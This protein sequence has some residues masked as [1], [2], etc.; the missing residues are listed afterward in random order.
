MPLE[1]WGI[2]GERDVS[3]LNNASTVFL[4]EHLPNIADSTSTSVMLQQA[5]SELKIEG[6]KSTEPILVN[7]TLVY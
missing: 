7:Y 5:C 6:E 1:L 4:G 3:V 2:D